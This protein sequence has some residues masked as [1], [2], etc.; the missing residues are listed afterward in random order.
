[1]FTRRDAIDLVST[2]IAYDNREDSDSVILAWREAGERARWTLPEAL[3]AVH[4]HFAESTGWIMPGHVTE[5]IRAT[6]RALA[7]RDQ[8][9]I[10]AAPDAASPER[11]RAIIAAIASKLGMP[12]DDESDAARREVACPWCHVQAGER[13]VNRHTGKILTKTA[14]HDQRREAYRVTISRA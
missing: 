11:F 1:M 12:G 4:S 8:A 3:D 9:A 5:R 6:R 10:E 7:A 14:C 2:I 13:C